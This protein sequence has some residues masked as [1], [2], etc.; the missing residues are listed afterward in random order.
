MRRSVGVQNNKV[1]CRY[2]IHCH[3]LFHPETNCVL[4]KHV[5][6]CQLYLKDCFKI[7]FH[8]MPQHPGLTFVSAV[9]VLHTT[10]SWH[11]SVG[12]DVI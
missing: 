7:A 8:I 9:N 3:C 11:S 1:T 2:I 5:K 4:F 12:N 10:E 6:K